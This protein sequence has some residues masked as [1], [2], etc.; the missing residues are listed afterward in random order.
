M[1]AVPEFKLVLV[2]DGGVGKTT[3]VKRHLTGEFEKKYVGEFCWT[4]LSVLC[5]SAPAVRP[6]PLNH[7]PAPL[8]PPWAWR[9]TR[10]NS[11]PTSVRSGS[12]SGTLPARRNT[13]MA[14]SAPRSLPLARPQLSACAVELTCGALRAR[15]P[16]SNQAECAIIMFDVTSRI[17][18]QNV[19]NWYRDVTRCVSFISGCS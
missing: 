19:P 3:F 16:C 1:T 10:W 12:T 11:S 2:G 17:T 13:A 18:Y 5:V 9:F 14:I 8:Q 4:A 6:A 15:A 7:P